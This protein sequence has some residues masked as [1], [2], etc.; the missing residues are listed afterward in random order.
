MFLKKVLPRLGQTINFHGLAQLPYYFSLLLRV[1]LPTFVL[2]QQIIKTSALGNTKD[3]F[4]ITRGGGNEN[5]FIR[6]CSQK[7]IR[8]QSFCRK[9]TS[10]GHRF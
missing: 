6:E 2:F 5:I 7:S 4:T 3:E 9:S 8:Q 10:S 1:T